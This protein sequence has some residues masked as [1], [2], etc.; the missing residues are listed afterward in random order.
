MKK[1]L[2][3]LLP[4]VAAASVARAADVYDIDGTH[5]EIGFKVR[6]L[7]IS[8]VKGKFD[9][10]EGNLTLD[11]AKLAGAE[12]KIDAASVNTANKDR[13]DHLRN[14]EF[15]NVAKFGSIT[16][17]ATKVE[18]STITGDLTLLGVTKPVTLEYTLSETVKDPWGNTK[19]GLSATGK[20]N[21][22]DF[23]MSWDKMPGAVGKE[24]EIAVDLEAAKRK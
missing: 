10:F 6:H 9:K 12:A 22:A 2:F 16:F 19:V 18:A 23:G 15:F 24:I 8:K 14:E 5:A 7:G 1:I 17:K 3:V 13:D 21:R 11:G 20:I 4:L